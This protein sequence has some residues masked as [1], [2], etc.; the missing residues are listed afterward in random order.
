MDTHLFLD[1]HLREWVDGGGA[2]CGRVLDSPG[3][4]QTHFIAEDGLEL[5]AFLPPPPFL[6]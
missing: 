4:S 6:I 5:L 1:I 2:Y 3:C